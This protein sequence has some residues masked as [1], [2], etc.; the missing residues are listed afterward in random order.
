MVMTRLARQLGSAVVLALI[1]AGCS[2]DLMPPTAPPAG[3]LPAPPPPAPPT[4]A[5]P[6]GLLWGFVVDGSGLCISDATAEIVRGTGIGQSVKQTTPCSAWDYDRGF[7]FK[8]LIAGAELTVRASA[9]GYRAAEQTFMAS[10]ASGFTSIG[11]VLTR[12]E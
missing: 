12:I 11:I 1:I 9:P 7:L 5:G 3:D 2:K 4:P 6:A 10:S 8:D